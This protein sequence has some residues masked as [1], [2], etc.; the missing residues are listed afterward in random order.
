MNE[1]H[2]SGKV[3]LVGAGPGD[4]GLLTIKGYEVLRRCD[5][6]IYDALVDPAIL[7]IVPTEAERIFVGAAHDPR[8]LA[9]CEIERLMIARAHQGKRVV[10]L[11]GGDPFIFGRGG[12][13]ALA[14]TRAG[15][16]WEVVPG[17][18]AGH[19]VPAAARIPLTCRG[20]ASSVA[21]VTGHECSDKDSSVAWDKLAQAA[22]TLV[23]FMGARTLPRIVEAL[24]GGGRLPTTPIAVIER[25]TSPHER[26]RVATLGTI[27]E[28]IARDPVCSPALIVVGEVVSLRARLQAEPE[29]KSVEVFD[30]VLSGVS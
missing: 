1:H 17:V 29:E 9:Q 7:A 2:R 16:P 21:F 26:V 30:D 3:Y 25:G 23:I 27:R 8:R 20:Y 19:G 18:S 28:M 13:E 15:V 14:L 11:K 22:D 5:V 6:V 10:R 4:P 12:E 24:L